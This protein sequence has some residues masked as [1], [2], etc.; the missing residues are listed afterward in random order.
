MTASTTASTR[1]SRSLTGRLVLFAGALILLLTTS[2]V[3]ARQERNLV[4]WQPIH[5]DIT[6]SLDENLT[7]VTKARTVITLR[8]N[9]KLGL[10]DLDFGE[11]PIDS[12]TVDGQPAR[13]ARAPGLLN[14]YLPRTFAR[15]ERTTIEVEYHGRPNDGLILSADKDGKPSATGDNWPNRVHHWI[16]CLDHPAAKATVNFTVSAPGKDLV[17][18]NGKLKNIAT[19]MAGTRTWSYAESVPIPPYCMVIAVGEYAKVEPRFAA[20]TPLTYYVPR[21]DA[22]I[23]QQGLSSAAPSLRF[24]SETIAPYPYEKLDLIVGA[25][26]FGGMENSSAIVFASNLLTPRSNGP[27]SRAFNINAALE[28]V[29]AHEIAHQ[30]FGD[31]VTEASWADLWLSEGFASYFAGLFVQTHDGEASFQIYMKRA[32]E[33][34]L[35]YE[36]MTRTPLHDTETENLMRLLNANNYQKGA[37]VL[38]MLRSELGDRAFFNGLRGYYAAHKNATANSNDLRAALE[39]A[40]GRNLQPFFASWVYGTGHPHY[41]LTWKWQAKA[42]I[43]RLTLKQLQSEGAFPNQIPV[44]LI[45]NGVTTNIVMRMNVKEVTRQFKLTRAPSQIKLDP[46]NTILKD[47]RVIASP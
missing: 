1:F 37:W 31:S 9:Q 23:A 38:H 14:V 40:S 34:Y 42:K 44:E 7:Q 33:S 21:S 32:A 16:P 47:A 45:D 26:R 22:A 17:I 46:N 12:V 24:F 29:I 11:M 28:E 36:K 20:I 25:T 35:S 6:I 10:V 18:A 39:K 4:A 8:I 19:E 5:Y 30:W 43:L 3:A 13:V 41:E 2:V 15:G 27:I